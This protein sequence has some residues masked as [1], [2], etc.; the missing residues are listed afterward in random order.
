VSARPYTLWRNGVLLGEI[1]DLPGRNTVTDPGTIAGLLKPTPAF[2]G[3]EPMMQNTVPVIPGHPTFQHIKER[4]TFGPAPTRSR[5]SGVASRILLKEIGL[6]GAEPT[7]GVAADKLLEIRD[8]DG[9]VVD[10]GLI[11]LDCYVI[12][13]DAPIAEIEKHWGPTPETREHWLVHAYRHKSHA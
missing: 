1:V 2:T 12:P 11:S 4:H 3:I 13:E 8:G 10:F 5:D 7:P 9:A 6:P